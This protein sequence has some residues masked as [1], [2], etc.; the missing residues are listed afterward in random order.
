MSLNC[1]SVGIARYTT[2][3]K[4]AVAEACSQD[5]SGSH[6]LRVRLYLG[7]SKLELSVVCL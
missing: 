1:A 3:V 4:A 2:R 7:A 6:S 5:L